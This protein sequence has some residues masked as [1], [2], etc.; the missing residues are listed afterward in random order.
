MRQDSMRAAEV[1]RCLRALARKFG[2]QLNRLD[3]D[4]VIREVLALACGEL[5][6]HGVVLRTQLA[7]EDEPVMD[8]RARL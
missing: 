2:P 3:F 1:I 5:L 7:E 8:D 6:R 4:D